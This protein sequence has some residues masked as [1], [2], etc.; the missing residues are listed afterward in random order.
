MFLVKNLTH[1]V[2]FQLALWTEK[3]PILTKQKKSYIHL[4]QFLK[5]SCFNGLLEL[6]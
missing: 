4:V 5:T 1:Q 6:G 2:S 3:E